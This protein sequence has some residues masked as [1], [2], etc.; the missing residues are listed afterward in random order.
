MLKRGAGDGKTWDW[1]NEDVNKLL[2]KDPNANFEEK[3]NRAEEKSNAAE[4]RSG[5][6]IRVVRKQSA[7]TPVTGSTAS[8]RSLSE[9]GYLSKDGSSGSIREDK[10][11]SHSVTQDIRAVH[12][13]SK[14]VLGAGESSAFPQTPSV[15][16]APPTAAANAANGA[17]NGGGGTPTMPVL[18]NELMM[19]L[20]Q[21]VKAQG[22][23]SSK[24]STDGAFDVAGLHKFLSK[25][26]KFDG[27][28]LE[29]PKKI[30][31]K[32]KRLDGRKQNG[33]KQNGKH[34][35][36]KSSTGDNGYTGQRT[37]LKRSNTLTRLANLADEAK[38]HKEVDPSKMTTAQSIK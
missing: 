1:H 38:A 33:R 19:L 18:N 37:K 24:D 15:K 9:P 25:A 17:A 20:Q 6:Q 2:P 28:F 10:P 11:R 13:R 32:Q 8:Q 16:T 12:N 5:I 3:S 22:F 21:V 14:I 26:A 35:R 30:S 36:K 4:E 31:D 27:K 29:K 23:A 34:D 7:V